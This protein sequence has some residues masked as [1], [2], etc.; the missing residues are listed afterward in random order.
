MRLRFWAIDV[1]DFKTV[2][3]RAEILK[4]SKKKNRL[5][6]FVTSVGSIE[7]GTIR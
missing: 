7:N 2:F 5:L 4:I 3:L 6:A 1:E